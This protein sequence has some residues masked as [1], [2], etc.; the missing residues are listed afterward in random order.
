MPKQQN[1]A[2]ENNLNLYNPRPRTVVFEGFTNSDPKPFRPNLTP[3]PELSVVLI[4]ERLN[5]VLLEKHIVTKKQLKNTQKVG[6]EG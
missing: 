1:N 2:D 6:L 4:L 5:Q 3:S